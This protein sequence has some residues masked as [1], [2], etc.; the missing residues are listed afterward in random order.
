M[1]APVLL[2]LGEFQFSLDTAAFEELQ[3]VT[4]YIWAEVPRIG[5][6]PALQFVGLEAET[7]T[8]AG[9]I[10]PHFRGGLGQVD[11]MR[12]QA[13]AGKP[14][15][16][17]DCL[18]SVKGFWCI[19]KVEE[20]R[21]HLWVSGAPRLQEFTVEL[22][23]YGPNG[24]DTVPRE[25]SVVSAPIGSPV[26]GR[27]TKSATEAPGKPGPLAK[28]AT[29]APETPRTFPRRAVYPF[30]TFYIPFLGPIRLIR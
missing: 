26:P 28:S 5:L 14:L 13:A 12:A 18:G 16:M 7:I 23:Y 10:Y 25:H 4:Q 17:V 11:A 3:R 29:E 2:N 24:S 20:G 22:K 1:S 21:R 30:G 19:T 15:L 27:F 9:K 8:L 6:N